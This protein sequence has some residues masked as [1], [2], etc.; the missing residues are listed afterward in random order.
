MISA[1]LSPLQK[2]ALQFAICD[3]VVK[4]TKFGNPWGARKH[5]PSVAPATID[6]LSS[7]NLIAP[8][9]VER[10][11]FVAT[12][13]GIDLAEKLGIPTKRQVKAPDMRTRAIILRSLTI[14]NGTV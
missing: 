1:R 9:L 11:E 5:L 3:A 13:S 7:Q 12:P 4:R 14:P 6:S 2:Q 8:R 10:S